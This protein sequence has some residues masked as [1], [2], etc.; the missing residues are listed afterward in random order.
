MAN[1]KVSNERKKELEQL[2]PFQENLIKVVKYTK[3]YQKQLSLI[4]GAIV[5]I[6]VVFSGI[7][8]SFEKSE[9]TASTRLSQAL[10]SYLKIGDAQKGY[11]AVKSDFEDIFKDYANTTA[12]KF[13]RIEFGKICF[14]AA[15]YDESF[16]HYKEAL[17]L[18]SNKASMENFILTALGHVCLAKND[19]DSAEKYFERVKNSKTNLL[20]DEALFTLGL[21]NEKKGDLDQG[22]ALFNQIVKEHESSIY[23][24]I[25]KSKIKN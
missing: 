12:G 15:K 3:T 2:D 20:K 8:Y 25:A 6:I 7:M 16:K 4:A 9:N 18:F 1:Q 19:T 10:T 21:I 5:L 13:A 23:A 24:S 22:R 14:S 11:D 17:T